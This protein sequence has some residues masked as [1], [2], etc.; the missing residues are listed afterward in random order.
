MTQRAIEINRN[1]QGTGVVAQ[2]LEDG[3]VIDTKSFKDRVSAIRFYENL[4]ARR[5]MQYS[6]EVSGQFQAT[7]KLGA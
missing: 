1:P 4:A 7:G 3:T 5:Y 2:I 6:W